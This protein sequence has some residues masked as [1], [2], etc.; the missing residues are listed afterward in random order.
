MQE[1]LKINGKTFYDTD[2]T[3]LF[4]SEFNTIS[5]AI[6]FLHNSCTVINQS[7]NV[8][9]SDIIDNL[10]QDFACEY[11]K[12]KTILTK[13]DKTKL[14]IL[15]NLESEE[16]I[17]VFM[18]VLTY[19]DKS[20]KRKVIDYLKEHQKLIINYTSE[21]EETLCLDYL[22]VIHDNKIVMEG[23]KEQILSEEKILKKLGFKLPFILE[24]SNGLKYY[25]LID[26]SY[27]DNESLVNALWK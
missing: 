21:I 14:S 17:F 27:Y 11:L 9:K 7:S 6:E 25:G 12:N 19:L 8:D 2:T 13:A 26:K 18:N 5:D 15:A 20:F 3:V 22:I 10:Y 23:K 1:I 4:T 16:K 24:L